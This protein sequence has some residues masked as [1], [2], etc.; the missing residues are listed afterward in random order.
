MKIPPYTTK[1]GLKIGSAYQYPLRQ[2]SYE[3]ERIQAALLGIPSRPLIS[4]WLAAAIALVCYLAVS[5][6]YKM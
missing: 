4:P 6:V 1:T 5:C 2:L 3:E